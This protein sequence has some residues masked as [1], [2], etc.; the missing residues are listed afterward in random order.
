MASTSPLP[1]VPVGRIPALTALAALAASPA[2]AGDAW[3][4][5]KTADGVT[6]EY[7][8]HLPDGYDASKAYP[9]VLALPPGN[10]DR[11]MVDAIVTPWG[12][13]WRAD[14]WIVV[15]PAAPAGA[16][17]YGQAAAL[18]PELLDHVAARHPIEGDKF[19]LLGI[20]NG[21]RSAFQVGLTTPERFAAIVVIPGVPVGDGWDRLEQLTGMSVTL[22]VGGE[23]GGW[24]SGSRRAT[25]ALTAAGVDAELVVVEGQGHSVF[26][27]VSY[28]QLKAWLTRE[29][30]G[31]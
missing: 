22:V 29:P 6:V 20:S 18:L 25:D 27:T 26:Q 19:H 9:A 14:G 23:D 3:Q 17:Y 13:D 7:Q 28:P 30:G 1:G 16:S 4:S 15:S 11:S 2:Y 8:L 24:T 10:Q 31:S 12:D 21:G 5:L